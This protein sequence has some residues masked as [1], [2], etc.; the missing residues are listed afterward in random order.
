MMKN[1]TGNDYNE[2]IEHDSSCGNSQKDISMDMEIMVK[3]IVTLV[4]VYQDYE[5]VTKRIANSYLT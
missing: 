1:T 2:S 5:Q 3:K 4:V